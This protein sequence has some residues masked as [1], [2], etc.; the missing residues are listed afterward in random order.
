MRGGGGE[1][2]ALPPGSRAR[3]IQYLLDLKGVRGVSVPWREGCVQPLLSSP[4]RFSA[5][6]KPPF[7]AERGVSSP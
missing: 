2:I 3:V 7:L 6:M 1:I 4:G 5:L